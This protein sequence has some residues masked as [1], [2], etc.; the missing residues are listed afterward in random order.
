[1]LAQ[2]PDIFTLVPQMLKSAMDWAATVGIF[3]V[4]L[5]MAVSLLAWMIHRS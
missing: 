5:G 1:M 2:I 4:A 3:I